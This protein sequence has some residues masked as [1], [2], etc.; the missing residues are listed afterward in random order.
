MQIA[1]RRKAIAA[2]AYAW[3]AL[4]LLGEHGRAREV[5]A[6]AN[7]LA[8]LEKAFEE[9]PDASRIMMRWWW[10]G[11]AVT[12]E[13]LGRELQAMKDAGIGGDA[14]HTKAGNEIVFDQVASRDGRPLGA[15]S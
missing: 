5:M 10:F 6:E 2:F 12:N 13:E 8:T 1:T 7:D 11:P 3:L 4:T 9:P 15:T 14:L